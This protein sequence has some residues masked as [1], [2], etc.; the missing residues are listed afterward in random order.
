MTKIFFHTHLTFI[1]GKGKSQRQE[2]TTRHNVWMK[3][4]RQD[5][6]GRPRLNPGQWLWN[7][8]WASCTLT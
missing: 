6:Y 1:N 2:T 8:W 4:C 7:L 5:W 3:N